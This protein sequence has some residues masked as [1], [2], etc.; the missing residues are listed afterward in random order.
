MGVNQNKTGLMVGAFLGLWHLLWS[1]LVAL[2][3][4]QPLL[5]FVYWMHFLNNPFTV[6]PF[7]VVTA[8]VLIVVTSAVGY[9]IGWVLAW[10][11]NK[12]HK[13]K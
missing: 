13:N 2:N 10:I 3:L 6:G 4:A 9:V 12:V 1:I 11:W 7:N 5:D 8:L